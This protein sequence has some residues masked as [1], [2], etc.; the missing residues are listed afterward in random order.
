MCFVTD[1]ESLSEFVA[2]VTKSVENQIKTLVLKRKEKRKEFIF[3]LLKFTGHSVISYDALEYNNCC[4]L[5]EKDG[6]VCILEVC[7][8]FVFPSKPPQFRLLSAYS[9]SKNGQPL[10]QVIQQLPFTETWDV[11]T[12][13][14]QVL[15]I[16]KGK[17]IEVFRDSTRSCFKL[18]KWIQDILE[19]KLFLI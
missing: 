3:Q 15:S 8:P 12:M 6:F 14:D 18:S 17:R 4:F 5:L 2:E 9:T 7:F 19:W 1:N 10:S 13:V 16:V 11:A